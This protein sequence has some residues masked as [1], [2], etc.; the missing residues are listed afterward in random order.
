LR[1]QGEIDRA[2]LHLRAAG[3][4]PGVVALVEAASLEAF[5]YLGYTDIARW[6]RCVPDD[7]IANS[8]ALLLASAV[9]EDASGSYARVMAQVDRLRAILPGWS[10]SPGQPSREWFAS[11]ADMWTGQPSLIAGQE[12][13]TLETVHAQRAARAE[14]RRHNSGW[15]MMK[16]LRNEAFML[17]LL[18]M[19][20]EAIAVLAAEDD[21]RSPAMVDL[22]N[23]I[24]YLWVGQ[25]R[26]DR[27]IEAAASALARA[28]RFGVLRTRAVACQFLGSSY[29][30]RLDLE[31]AEPA[32]REAFAIR[33]HPNTVVIRRDMAL[34]WAMA[35]CLTGRGA[36]ADA[37]LTRSLR[38]FEGVF[39]PWLASSLRSMRVRLRLFDNDRDGAML[40]RAEVS[41]EDVEAQLRYDLIE[42][43]GLTAIQYALTIGGPGAGAA[44]VPEL[45]GRIAR[46][47]AG[48]DQLNAIRAR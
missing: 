45:T 41:V 21:P 36:E 17:D 10:G 12:T 20:D 13:I 48:R 46:M 28:D 40:A 30:A 38:E 31:A 37:L 4:E 33:S 23:F 16:S 7:V 44:A 2:I 14:M 9:C 3:D 18:G 27:T 47:P 19:T 6:L 8:P 42:A 34:A 32:L 1:E 15:L 35:L 26:P 5:G 29:L 22:P 43:P 25:G 11:A 39:S 24:A